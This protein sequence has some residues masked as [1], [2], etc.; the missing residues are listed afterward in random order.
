MRQVYPFGD[1]S[2]YTAS[3]A[4]TASYA[5]DVDRL[6]YVTSA[7]VADTILEPEAGT[8]ATKRYCLISYNQYLTLLSS[9]NYVEVCPQ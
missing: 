8:R 9:T 7:S 4:Q 6:V 3:F 5:E 2:L 1:T